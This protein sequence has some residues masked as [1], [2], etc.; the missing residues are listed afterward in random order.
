MGEANPNSE[1]PAESAA[2]ESGV[3][4]C[5]PRVWED[6]DTEESIS[7]ALVL[8]AACATKRPRL[9]M[10]TGA[11][12]GE[13]IA[14]DDRDV[15]A[16][17]RSMAV[18]IH[19]D[20]PSISRRHCLL[21]RRDGALQLE[22]LESRN[23]TWVNGVKVKSATLSDGDRVQVGSNT[24]FNVRFVD[25]VEDD[26]ARRLVEASLR[27]PLTGTY[28]RRY[29]HRR[30]EAEVAYARRYSTGLAC[31]ILDL[32]LFKSVN[33]TYGHAAGDAVLAAVGR[34]LGSCVRNEDVVTRFG[35]EEFALLARVGSLEEARL[36]A[37]RLR[38]CIQ[39]LRIPLPS[40]TH[41]IGVTISAGVATLDELDASSRSCADFVALADERLYLAKACGRNRVEAGEASA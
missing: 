3:R 35:G 4:T 17:G 2:M 8:A 28:N 32:D 23:G 19:V 12:A 26:L 24:V 30:L 15:F 20:D 38:S 9:M 5:L 25:E 7:T 13:T 6:D 16:I 37:E 14:L 10:M 41:A 33:D 39:R 29:L 18:E 34:A 31:I 11:R 40:T 36:F 1:F 27:D 22:D 21:L